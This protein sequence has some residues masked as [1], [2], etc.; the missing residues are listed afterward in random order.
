M[1][2]KRWF[3]KGLA[4]MVICGIALVIPTMVLTL[5]D[6]TTVLGTIA[7]IMYFLLSI[8]VLG[9]TVEFVNKQS[10]LNKVK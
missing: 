5:F 3:I 10:I 4:T 6:L 1:S 2:L 7:R 8:F 9:W